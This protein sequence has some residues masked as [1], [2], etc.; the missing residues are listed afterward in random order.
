MVSSNPPVTMLLDLLFTQTIRFAQAFYGPLWETWEI[1]Y[2]NLPFKRDFQNSRIAQPRF[3]K[4]ASPSSSSPTII[5]E[6]FP[7]FLTELR[8]LL[9]FLL[10][11]YR[12]SHHPSHHAHL[13]SQA[14]QCSHSPCAKLRFSIPAPS[15]PGIQRTVP[16]FHAHASVRMNTI[17]KKKRQ[18]FPSSRIVL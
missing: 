17:K 13:H 1:G 18:A 9:S 10:F 12:F 8:L 2:F 3:R 7:L 5:S 15:I 11:L 4:P 16:V 6:E 14:P